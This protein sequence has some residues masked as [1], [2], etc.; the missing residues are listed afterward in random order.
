MLITIPK[1]QPIS[2]LR[3]LQY[4]SKHLSKTSVDQIILSTG[5]V[6]LSIM[7]AM[8]RLSLMIKWHHLA[9]VLQE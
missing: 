4:I 1:A 7:L 9:P 6:P 3:L 5:L 8:L 2:V